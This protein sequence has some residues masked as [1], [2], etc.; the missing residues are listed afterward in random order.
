[1]NDEY[2][3][4]CNSPRFVADVRIASPE[5][6]KAETW[7]RRRDERAEIRRMGQIE[8]RAVVARNKAKRLEAREIAAQEN[9][10]LRAKAQAE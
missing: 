6:D 3:V 8:R 5:A 4:S 10:T 9:A 7:M 1:M 2:K